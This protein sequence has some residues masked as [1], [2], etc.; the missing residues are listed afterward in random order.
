MGASRSQSR[1]DSS[2][3][4]ESCSCLIADRFAARLS[5][6]RASKKLQLASNFA[7]RGGRCVEWGRRSRVGT[8]RDAF[9]RRRVGR[10][11]PR[12]DDREGAKNEKSAGTKRTCAR[13]LLDTPRPCDMLARGKRTGISI[14]C[15]PRRTFTHSRRSGSNPTEPVAT[16]GPTRSATERR[17]FKALLPEA[18]RRGGGTPHQRTA[19]CAARSRRVWV[20]CDLSP[21]FEVRGMRI[22]AHFRQANERQRPSASS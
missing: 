16:Q 18:H 17:H 7:S 6:A 9:A 13:T 21:C 4:C 5:D 20:P 3:C 10:R 14:T 12:R 8:S 22:A 1:N 15:R 19:S 2:S 11:K